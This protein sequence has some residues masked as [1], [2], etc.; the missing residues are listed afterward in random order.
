MRITCRSE[1]QFTPLVE[2]PDGLFGISKCEGQ[3]KVIV[4]LLPSA[5][6]LSKGQIDLRV[7]S[8]STLSLA[9]HG[10]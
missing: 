4:P 9:K 6:G 10:R 7:H 3:P 1:L 2:D 5:K 8:T